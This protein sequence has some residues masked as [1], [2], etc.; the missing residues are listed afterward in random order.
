MDEQVQPKIQPE[1]LPSISSPTMNVPIKSIASRKIILIVLS[2]LIFLGMLSG[3]IY[4]TSRFLPFKAATLTAN[5]PL[6]TQQLA[7]VEGKILKVQK[8]S[9][10]VENKDGRKGEIE[11]SDEFVINKFDSRN[12]LPI[13]SRDIKDIE[14]NKEAVITL[15][16]KDG[17]YK[18]QDIR[19]LG[20][21]QV[22]TLENTSLSK[23]ATSSA[24]P[25]PLG[26]P[27][28]FTNQPV[29]V[30]SITPSRR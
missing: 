29:A 14:L 7:V 30:P 27:P 17:E 11:L 12:F 19:Y 5:N 4:V 23:P 24:S 25:K 1:S 8:N 26:S 22:S 2:V 6:Y 9:L 3:I 16:F 10:S 20:A 13:N 18:V 21:S 15:V 28:V